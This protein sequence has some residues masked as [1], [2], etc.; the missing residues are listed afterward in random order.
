MSRAS[1]LLGG[2]AASLVAAYVP[3]QRSEMLRAEQQALAALH[4]RCAQPEALRHAVRA[5]RA[6][7]SD[8]DFQAALLHAQR[9]MA[10]ATGYDA[11]NFA[12]GSTP[13]PSWLKVFE[14]A[15][16]RAAL[17]DDKG[18]AALRYYVL[19]SSL[20]W[21]CFY[22]A[23]VHGLRSHGIELLPV[24]AREAIGVARD[25]EVD[26]VS[27][28]CADMLGCD[29]SAA[30]ILLLTSQCWDGPMLEKLRAK[31][32]REL[33]E[34]ALVIDYTAAMGEGDARQG[35]GERTF[36]LEWKGVGEVSWG[37]EIT[38][39]V[40]RVVQVRGASRGRS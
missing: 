2:P 11:T 1:E 21:L 29:L 5:L 19:G 36:V 40:W 30:D 28:E 14:S 35:W 25:A 23:C 17:R 24:L 27:F 16:L 37:G 33:R 3:P 9:E 13:L 12:Y 39:W 8:V 20:G 6:L 34:G 18:R 10:G 7:E 26:G 22:G 4:G 15:P 32:L 38:F 31:L